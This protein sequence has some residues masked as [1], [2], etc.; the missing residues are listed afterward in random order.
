MIL[1]DTSVLVDYLK[2]SDNAKTDLFDLV[3]EQRLPYAITAYTYQEIL[4]GARDESEYKTLTDYLSTQIVFFLTEKINVYEKAARMFY[5]LRRKG[6][7]PRSTIDILIAMVAIENDLYLLH[8]DKDF[9]KIASVVEE[10]KIF[11]YPVM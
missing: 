8:N 7:T 2:G 9:D 10:L 4:Q 11:T 3:L 6:R 1:V 5:E